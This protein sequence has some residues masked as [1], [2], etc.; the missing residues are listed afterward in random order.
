MKEEPVRTADDDEIL[1][2]SDVFLNMSLKDP[3]YKK[4]E[5]DVKKEASESPKVN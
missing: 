5:D 1:K 3:L 4:S 2:V